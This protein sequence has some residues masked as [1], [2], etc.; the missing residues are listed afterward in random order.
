MAYV[1]AR[2]R[3]AG[4]RYTGMYLD[5]DGTYKSAGTFDTPERAQE[6]A[7]QNERHHRL[8]LAETSPAEK[9]TITIEDFGVKFLK[10]HA[11]EPN[12]KMTY[13]QLLH[14]HIYP[15]VGE[16]RVAEIAR[17]SACTK[18]P[19]RVFAWPLSSGCLFMRKLS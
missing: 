14:R 17:E 6:V 1:I 3:K 19:R 2:R 12:S 10:E 11:I 5:P 8:R 4:T 15:Y 9:A 16:R 7:E 18:A 13:A